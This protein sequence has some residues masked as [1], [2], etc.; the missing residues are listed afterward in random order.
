MAIKKHKFKLEE[1]NMKILEE[2][3]SYLNEKSGRKF[4]LSATNWSCIKSCI[5]K[6]FEIEDLKKV[7]DFK[8]EQWKNT[9]FEMYIRPKTLFGFNIEKYLEEIKLK[10]DI[11]SNNYTRIKSLSLKDIVKYIKCPRTINESITEERC[12]IYESCEKCTLVWLYRD[13]L[14]KEGE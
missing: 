10:N 13:D 11:K 3:I 7:V 9:D 4:E 1:E 8:V 5:K 14:L 6:G 2:V 12:E